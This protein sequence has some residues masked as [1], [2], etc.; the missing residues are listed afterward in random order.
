MLQI[1]GQAALPMLRAAIGSTVLV[2]AAGL[3]VVLAI[4]LVFAMVLRNN[5]DAKK[6]A[7]GLG[8]DAHQGPLGQPRAPSSQP[9]DP[10][11]QRGGAYPPQGWGAE[12]DFGPPQPTT[13]P[14]G[15][16]SWGGGYGEQGGPAAGQ[17]QWSGAPAG[18]RWGEPAGQPA[19]P[20]D[21]GQANGQGWGAPA[22]QRQEPGAGRQPAGWAQPAAGQGNAPGGWAQPAP[23]T[24]AWGGQQA[25]PN[26]WQGQPAAAMPGGQ[27]QPAWGAPAA[28]QPE[29][30]NPPTGAPAQPEWANPPAGTAAYADAAPAAYPG[31]AQRAAV[32]VVRQGKEPGRTYDM[33]RDRITIGRSRESDI[34][35]EDL[36]VSRLHTTV[37]HDES[38]R[39][40]LRDENS[41]N[42]TFVNG[43]RVSE[44][45]LDEGDEVQVGQTVLGFVRH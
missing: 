17:G 5:G 36:A 44:K 30:A 22:P 9:L 2:A 6:T 39:Y 4:V 14:G 7:G 42:G 35:L 26:G 11:R 13:G 10:S 19:A 3:V 21:N 16:G 27:G 25:G 41:A 1:L 33:R 34:F 28:A 31:S 32:L 20:W 12:N 43:Q 23:N 24:P 18:N 40:I 15:P 45:A 8:F 38:G 29:W 37:T